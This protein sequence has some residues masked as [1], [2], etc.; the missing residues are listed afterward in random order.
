MKDYPFYNF[1]FFL[2]NR[3]TTGIIKENYKKETNILISTILCFG[4]ASVA[5]GLQK[6]QNSNVD[7]L[8]KTRSFPLR[9]FS[10]NETK[11]AVFYG[12][13]HIY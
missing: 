5:K 6:P 9:I 2:K 12:F 11:P 4:I 13:G 7:I 10:A 8:H 3:S 1:S